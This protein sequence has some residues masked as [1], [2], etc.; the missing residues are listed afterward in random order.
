MKDKATKRR[1]AEERNR[2]NQEWLEAHRADIDELAVALP[3]EDFG[4]DE[5]FSPKGESLKGDGNEN[6]AGKDDGDP[7][8]K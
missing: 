6:E 3:Y 7:N 2:K 1:E 4:W 8:D 5:R